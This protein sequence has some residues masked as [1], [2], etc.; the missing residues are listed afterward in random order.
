MI[1]IE[2][3][4][5]FVFAALKLCSVFLMLPSTALATPLKAPEMATPLKVMLDPGHG[6]Y[7]SGAVVAGIREADLVLQVTRQLKELLKDDP[8]F[9]I[10]V[11]RDKDL[12]VSLNERV[13]KAEQ[14]KVD[15]FLSLHVNSNSDHRVQGM[16]VYIQ[17][18]LP[19]DDESLLLASLENQKEI[20]HNQTLDTADSQSLSKKTDLAMIIEDLRQ[21]GRLKSSH[22]LSSHLAEAWPSKSSAGS[23]P[24]ALNKQK[25]PIRQA[26]FFVITKLG[27]PAALIE[28]GFLTHPKERELLNQKQTQKAMADAIYK[29]LISY[30]LDKDSAGELRSMDANRRPATEPTSN[31]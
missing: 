3:D 9:E 17:N 2:I 24:P 7:D 14:A 18:H 4:R 28:L 19:A 20:I 5:P 10:L 22:R 11:T 31:N 1:K 12:K 21:A 26:P 6:G 30:L 23:T 13:K 15:L 25:P 27:I 8:R 29:G 16:E